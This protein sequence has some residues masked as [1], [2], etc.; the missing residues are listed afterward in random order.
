HQVKVSP[1]TEERIWKA[2]REL[3]YHP[4]F[5]AR[6]LRAQRSGMIGFSWE[7]TPPDQAN[8]IYNEF[9]E[10]IIHYSENAGFHILAFPYKP[11]DEWINAYRDLI[12]TN[13]VD[14]FILSS[15]EYDDKRIKFLQEQTF[16]FVAFGRSNPEWHFP[17][18][19]VDG[20]AGM[21][22]VVEHLVGMGH[23]RIALLNWSETKSTSVG[24]KR[25]AGCMEALQKAGIE[26]QT[27]WIARG[28]GDF[29][30][31]YQT[32]MQWLDVPHAQ[33]PTAIIAFSDIMAIGAMNAA[34]SL[35][36]R[37]GTDLAITGFDDSPLTQYTVPSLTSVHQP[38]WEVGRITAEM[39]QGILNDAPPENQS[40]LL[41][42]TLIIRDSSSHPAR[43]F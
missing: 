16:P 4:N 8:Q 41:Q 30:F 36:V 31:A 7:P 24:K 14:G 23:R 28:E 42:P 22:L 32:S 3:G 13:R 33:R 40:V 21:R 29:P 25:M 43:V 20:A 1:Q 19:D 35:G 6:S 11:G 38:I 10:S 5:I 12:D 39:F 9:M 34:L 37:V 18:V 2:A 15:V 27:G 26:V 17:F